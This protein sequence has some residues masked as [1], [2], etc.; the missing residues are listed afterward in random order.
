[1]LANSDVHVVHVSSPNESMYTYSGVSPR[2]AALNQGCSQVV[3]QPD[4]DDQSSTL[5]PQQTEGSVYC[6][7]CQMWLNGPTHCED[8]KICKK[9][10]KNCAPGEDGEKIADDEKKQH[11]VQMRS[12]TPKCAREGLRV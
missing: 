6:A 5:A 11:G 12:P 4:P 10:R 3:F 2:A 9:H 7:D 1:M 8:H